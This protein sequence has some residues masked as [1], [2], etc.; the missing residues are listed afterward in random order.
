[1]RRGRNKRAATERGILG[2]DTGLTGFIGPDEPEFTSAKY[3]FAQK[4]NRMQRM[5]ALV[6]GWGRGIAAAPSLWYS[7]GHM[8][9]R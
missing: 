2:I 9:K 1:M 5:F 3:G 6:A 7:T 4:K 8:R